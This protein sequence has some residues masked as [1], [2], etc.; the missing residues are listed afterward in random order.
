MKEIYII[1]A[2]TYGEAICELA[3]ICGYKIVGFLDDDENKFGQKVMHSSVIG[4]FSDLKKD[5]VRYKNFAVAIGNNILRCEFIKKINDMGGYTPTLVHPKAEV[6]RYAKLGKGVFIQA[7][8][9]IWTK[10]CLED[11]T[12]ISPNTV[13]THHAKLG[14]GCLISGGSVVGALVDVGDYVFAGMG[15]TIMTGVNYVGN[16]TIIGAGTTVTKNLPANCTAVGCP[17]KVIKFHED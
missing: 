1:G 12:I 8:A 7:G 15:S 5:Q 16:N 6:S 9:Y 2:G 13:V 4:S 10:A 11:G 3:E 17:A 14:K